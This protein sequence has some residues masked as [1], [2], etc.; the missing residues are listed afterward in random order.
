LANPSI[1]WELH[2]GRLREKPG[3]SVGHNRTTVRLGVMLANQLDERQFEVRIDNSRV[4][5]AEVTYY[6]PDLFVA[7]AEQ[8]AAIP[9]RPGVL[10]VYPDPLPLVVE[11][12]STSTGG[13][14][15]RSK[16]PEY[17]GR[18]DEEIWRIH[19]YDRTLKAWR[20]QPDG[21]YSEMV[22][23]G[24]RV[25]PIALPGVSIDLDALFR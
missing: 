17:Q 1:K 25:E 19:P 24:G 23:T 16:L 15:V 3:M 5:R 12:W 18:G 9:D 10:E 20:R 4:R 7:R 13:Y 6:V 22:F 14:D 2:E 21:S 11:I 8:T